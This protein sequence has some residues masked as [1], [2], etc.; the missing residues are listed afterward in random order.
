MFGFVFLAPYART[1][2]YE[3]A[4][5][6]T[7]LIIMPVPN[8]SVSSVQH[9]YRYRTLRYVRYNIIPAPETSVRSV[10]HQYW[11]RTLRLVRYG[12]NNGTGIDVCTGVGTGIRTTSIPVMDTSVRSAQHQPGTGHFGNI[13]TT[14]SREHHIHGDIKIRLIHVGQLSWLS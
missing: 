14:S 1:T 4:F 3:E 6:P 2:R 12:V 7:G 5:S 8:T 9:Q 10:R 11:Y 13:G